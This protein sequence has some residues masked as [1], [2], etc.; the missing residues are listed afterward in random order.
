MKQVGAYVALENWVSVLLQR[1]GEGYPWVVL[2]PETR[3]STANTLV[4]LPGYQSLIALD[5]GLQLTLWGNLPE[6]SDRPPVFESVVM[7][8]DPPSGVDLD[9][10]LDRGRVVVANRKPSEGSA[11]VRV[12]FLSEVW[13]VELP[14]TQSEVGLELWTPPRDS[15]CQVARRL[16]RPVYERPCAGEDAATKTSTLATGHA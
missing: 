14:D 8:N 5:S 13:Q 7:L 11:I 3:V 2:R 10:T 12:R 9:F 6:F 4:S 16:R 1:Q 15:S